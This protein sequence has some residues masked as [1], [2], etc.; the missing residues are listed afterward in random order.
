MDFINFEEILNDAVFTKPAESINLEYKEASFELPNS[1]WETVSSFANTVGGL[2]VL[3]IKEDKEKHEYEIVGVDD[4][5]RI[6]QNMFNLN[7]NPNCLSKPVLS[8][9]DVKVTTWKGKKLIQV[10]VHPEQYNA[11]PLKAKKIAYVRT[12]DGDRKASEDQLQYFLIEQ[13]RDIDTALLN[14]FDISDLNLRT[15]NE[16]RNELAART[17]NNAY[18]TEDMNKFLFDVGAFRRDRTSSEKITKLCKG[19]L[20][21]FGK[22]NSIMDVFPRFQLDY[23]R[24]EDDKTDDWSDRVSPGDMNFPD[25]NI[26]SFYKQ[27]L[28]K[29][30][31]G[32]K[33]K[34]SQ[35][36]DLARGSYYSDL[37]LAA[38]EALVNALMHAY[39]NGNT[40]VKVIDR[41]SY[42]EFSNPGEMRVS[43]E[44]FL[45]GQDSIIRND[46]ISTLFR[47]IGISEKAASGGPRI[48]R[49]ATRNHLVDPDVVVDYE[50]NVTKVRIWKVDTATYFSHDFEL[51]SI[52]KVIINYAEA[53]GSF[54]FPELLEATNNQYGSESTLRKRL[55][56][57]ISENIIVSSGNGRKTKYALMKTEEQM[58]VEKIKKVKEFENKLL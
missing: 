41:P 2:I 56:H 48:L 13:Q 44:S 19:G 55:R 10:L 35:D 9:Q 16:Y 14:N 57:L 33:D 50:K 22:F 20:L 25:L 37:E 46:E 38:K 24:Y 29:L 23:R 27:V 21:F 5:E 8:D 30:R 17:D 6:R 32:I 15:V 3:G 36:D 39:Y 12:D 40:A 7:N 52:E 42:F 45:R 49:A 4:V 26:F 28:P 18:V 43:T 47:R 51:D 54:K 53:H 11:R 31:V 34:Y 1:F 58:Q